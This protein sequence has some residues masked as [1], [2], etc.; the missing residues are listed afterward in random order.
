MKQIGGPLAWILM[1]NVF[2]NFETKNF[3]VV[4]ISNFPFAL[5]LRTCSSAIDQTPGLNGT[6]LI[7]YKSEL[8]IPWFVQNALESIY[9][10]AR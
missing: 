4:K 6:Q 5:N 3:E 7:Q 2:W 10:P 8:M 9:L 1:K